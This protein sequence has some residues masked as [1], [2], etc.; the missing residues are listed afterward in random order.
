VALGPPHILPEWP[1]GTRFGLVAVVRN[2]GLADRA[3]T[4][5]F[6]VTTPE[7]MDALLT[8]HSCR[9]LWF[10]VARHQVTDDLIEQTLTDKEIP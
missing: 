10:T 8:R 3:H 6:W 4:R 5:A 1:A 2:R 9:I 7:E